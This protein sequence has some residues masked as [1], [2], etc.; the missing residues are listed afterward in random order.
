MQQ[1]CERGVWSGSRTFPGQPQAGVC[2]DR[3]QPERGTGETAKPVA[4]D[5]G[6]GQTERGDSAFRRYM[7][8]VS[9]VDLLTF[10]EEVALA[11]RVKRGDDKAREQMITANLRLVVRIAREYEGLGLPLLDLINE[12]NIGLMRAVE[13][14]DPAKGSKLSS[15]SSWWIR[16]SMRRAL[17]SQ[18]RTIR[19]PINAV[20]QLR[21]ISRLAVQFREAHGR[22][23]TDGELAKQM[24]L[25]PIRVAE[26]R[27]TQSQLASLDMPIGDGA[28]DLLGDLVQDEA[29]ENPYQTV[30]DQSS[31]AR[32]AE[33]LT[34]LAPRERAILEH[35][36]G[37][38]G[39][40]VKTLEEIGA[41]LGVTRERIRQLQNSALAKLR[42]LIE[43]NQEMQMAV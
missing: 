19:L 26:L 21:E 33:L 35:R 25:R 1:T 29:A 23:A 30:E 5:A 37:L 18:S 42:H 10:E 27:Q 2:S 4:F 22:E 7:R 11:A 17:A 8:D 16:Q 24:G 13:K 28:G 39:F 32:M 38:N 3:P 43:Q 20:D 15:Y 9:Q 34:T 36:F 12:G 40:R 6:V 41:M 14:Y 31:L